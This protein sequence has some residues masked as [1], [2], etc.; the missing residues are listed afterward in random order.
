MNS[1]KSPLWLAL[2]LLLNI[3][4]MVQ[5]N[6]TAYEYSGT[7]TDGT[8]TDTG[9]YG[10]YT[11]DDQTHQLTD[12]I[13]R[14]DGLT[15]FFTLA[16]FT[17]VA[18]TDFQTFSLKS[19]FLEIEFIK[20]HSRTNHVKWDDWSVWNAF[21][22]GEVPMTGDTGGIATI[23]PVGTVPEPSTVMFLLGGLA[24]L[25]YVGKR[26]EQLRSAAN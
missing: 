10:S 21:D 26:R 24:A 8:L 9:F 23:N 12:F 17:S 11:Y 15:T 1:I 18:V 14:Y 20:T 22:Y 13:Q 19:K 4:G 6:Q 2:G 5:A 25:R 7:F 3:P 16:D